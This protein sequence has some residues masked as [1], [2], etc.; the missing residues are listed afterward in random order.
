MN[1]GLEQSVEAIKEIEVSRKRSKDE[2]DLFNEFMRFLKNGTIYDIRLPESGLLYTIQALRKPDGSLETYKWDEDEINIVKILGPAFG[3]FLSD[4]EKEKIEGADIKFNEYYFCRFFAS[5]DGEA[6]WHLS[7]EPIS[8]NWHPFY[9]SGRNS[10]A[11]TT[12]NA[13]LVMDQ[14]KIPEGYKQIFELGLTPDGHIEKNKSRGFSQYIAYKDSK[15]DIFLKYYDSPMKRVYFKN[16]KNNEKEWK[17]IIEDFGGYGDLEK[18]N[19]IKGLVE[20]EAIKVGVDIPKIEW[21]LFGS[22]E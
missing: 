18:R 22:G 12:K 7:Q 4:D 17:L 13:N 21:Y 20:S 3:H 5:V 19:R 11:S 2:E 15:G 16:S 10:V 9:M 6:S 14:N 1:R 8:K